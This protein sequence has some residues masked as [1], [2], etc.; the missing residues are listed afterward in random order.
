MPRFFYFLFPATILGILLV[1]LGETLSIVAT[2]FLAAYL[3]FPLIVK[4]ESW[5]VPHSIAVLGI[6]FLVLVLI[7]LGLAFFVPLLLKEAQHFLKSLPEIIQ[8]TAFLIEN[9]SMDLGYPIAFDKNVLSN[10]AK[11]YKSIVGINT[12]KGITSFLKGTFSGIA[13]ILVALMN[14]FLFPIFF[15]HIT[16]DYKKLV[17]GFW[18][19]IPEPWRPSLREI[20][21]EVNDI[22]S[23]FIRGQLVVITLL[24]IC[25]ALTLSLLGV[26]FGIVIGVISGFLCLIPYIG[27][28]AGL[29][30]AFSVAL[31]YGATPFALGIIVVVFLGLQSLEGLVITPKVVGNRVGLSPLW[32][33]LALIVGGNIGGLA[34]MFLAIPLG[35]VIWRLVQR[36]DRNFKQHFSRL[37]DLQ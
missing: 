23:A 24:G 12:I 4:L 13:D 34:G 22:F 18:G 11:E 6:L 27:P 5:K 21:R 36:F 17:K 26:R 28:I 1:G 3:T 14:I 32:A 2:S 9:K 19:M 16:G 30:T 15:F 37:M 31:A 29:A 33:L 35:G 8:R 20:A 10:L 7:L 25:Y